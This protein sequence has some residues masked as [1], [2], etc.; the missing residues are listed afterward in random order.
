VHKLIAFIGEKLS[1]IRHFALK[2][3]LDLDLAIPTLLIPQKS[4]SPSLLILNLGKVNKTTVNSNV[5][6]ISIS[7]GQLKVENFFKLDENLSTT[8]VAIDNV[9][10]RLDGIQVK[11]VLPHNLRRVQQFKVIGLP[12]CNDVSWHSGGAGTNFRAHD[13]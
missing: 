1:K 2:L 7:I 8:T 3:Q 10:A 11:S 4:D 13:S 5:K 6:N 9:L 12:S